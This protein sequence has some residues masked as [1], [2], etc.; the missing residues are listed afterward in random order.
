M[1]HGVGPLRAPS[2][3]IVTQQERRSVEN[4]PLNCLGTQPRSVW[5][6]CLADGE[7]TV[8]SGASGGDKSA[9]PH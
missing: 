4:S 3:G 5:V 8:N 2:N 9:A 6:L 1:K 7:S